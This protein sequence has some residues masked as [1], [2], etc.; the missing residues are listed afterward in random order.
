MASFAGAVILRGLHTT[1]LFKNRDRHTAG[2][3]D[4]LLHVMDCFGVR[5]VD[6]VTGKACSLSISVIRYGLMATHT[7]VLAQKV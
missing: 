3:K 4:A 7:H 6:M 2:H 5:G 1:L